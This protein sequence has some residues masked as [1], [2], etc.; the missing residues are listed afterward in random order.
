[1][2]RK[3]DGFTLIEILVLIVILGIVFSLAIPSFTNWMAKYKIEEDTKKVYGFLQ[4]ARV[5]AFSE[6]IKLNVNV[7][8]NQVC[9]QCDSSDSD[10]VSS[11]GSGSIKCIELNFNFDGNTVNISRRGTFSGG[12]IFY[13]SANEAQYDCV[14]V[15]DIR[16]KMEKCNG[17]P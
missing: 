9:L 4:E 2:V 5:K 3:I 16:V 7:N 8:N 12:P 17:N 15:S 1:M 13:P 14:R 10:C 11:Y 6:K